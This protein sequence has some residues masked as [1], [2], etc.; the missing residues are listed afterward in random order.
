MAADNPNRSHRVTINDIAR[1]A[2]VSKGAVSYALNGR[3]GLSEVTRKRILEIADELGWRPNSAARSLSA[4]RANA[5]GLVLSR[6]PRTL[7]VESF[8]PEFLAGVESELSARSVALMLQ[9]AS[10]VESEAAVYR[11]W[12]AERRVDGVL[13]IDLRIGDPRVDELVHLGL[14]AVVVGGPVD[15]QALP[16][17]WHDERTV[18]VELVRYLAALGHT[19][20]ARVAG[21]AGFVHST[22]RTTAFQEAMSEL[23]LVARVIT[24]D[25][26]PESG[27]R[28]TR[29]L[30]SDPEP[31]TAI[32]Y[33]SDVL[34]VTGLG[35]AQQMG[36]SVPGD[37][38][39]VAWDDS[40][41]CQ[42][43]HPPLTTVSRDI[44]EY[45]ALACKRLLAAIED[46]GNRANLESP[47][48]ELTTRASTGPAPAS[49]L[50]SAGAG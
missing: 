2:G 32:A 19:R 9:L 1:R 45:G 37:V 33:D 30:L 24:T 42:V 38:S 48:G 46:P 8:F 36:F 7:A 6:P 11:R 28:A 4:S 44:S 39:I 20:I 34:A 27:A 10:D 5:C 3:P 29:Q 16:A 15:G 13:I 17:V 21:V 41:L 23:D 35:V 12:W 47:R 49:R 25:Y 14:P 43:V 26:T 40:L 22:I 50:R 31:P 18:V